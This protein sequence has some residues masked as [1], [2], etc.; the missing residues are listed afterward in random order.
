MQIQI[1]IK[2]YDIL[3]I[4]KDGQPYVQLRVGFSSSNHSV[5]RMVEVPSPT[6]KAKVLAAVQQ[7]A[8]DTKAEVLA[9]LKQETD[10]KVY[11]EIVCPEGE[12]FQM[13]I[14]I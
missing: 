10:S 3:K 7:K 6:T 1:A 8:I 14:D 12:M 2:Y 9:Q 5:M 11:R 13:E 4:E